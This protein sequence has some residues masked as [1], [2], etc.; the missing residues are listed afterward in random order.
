MPGLNLVIADKDQHYLDNV[1]DFIYTGYQNRFN[2]QAFSNE[3]SFKEY[4][5]QVNRIDILL[6][7]PDFYYEH[8]PWER[9]VA[10]IVLSSGILAKEVKNCEIISK[11]QTGDKLVSS[12]LN[13]FSEKSSYEVPATDGTKKAKVVSFFS[14]CG[15]SGKSSLAVLAGIW[16]AMK[17]KGTFYL[18]ME[19]FQ[20]T[21]AY[22]K[23]EGVQ[24]LSNILFYLKE[25]NKNLSLKIEGSRLVD[26]ATGV[27]YF[28]P[29]E[30]VFDRDDLTK[31]E[32]ETL[33]NQL[34]IMDCY[35]AVIVDMDSGFNNLNISLLENSD[36]IFLVLPQEH[37]CR[38]K[39]DSLL[40]GFEILHKRKGINILEKT[41]IILNKYRDNSLP[42]FEGI[43]ICNKPVLAKVP[44]IKGFDL[45]SGASFLND[46]GNPVS[47]A[48]TRIVSKF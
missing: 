25:N 23:G 17:E 29:P 38:V 39:M 35:D 19:R 31:E 1:V 4:L 20:T 6:I 11:Y 33:V 12:I 26:Q 36:V 46:A 45:I 7:S 14:P 47:E 28:L 48:L 21:K 32:I 41:E 40:Q 37:V 5:K 3:T 8:L 42:E 18:N 16:C 22:F 43:D 24:N 2:I 15:G 34:R 44:F 30:N 10:P 9:I 27:H 13:V